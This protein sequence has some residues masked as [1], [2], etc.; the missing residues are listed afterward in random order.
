MKKLLVTLALASTIA[1]SVYGQGRILFNNTLGGGLVTVAADP[2]NQGPTGGAGGS[3]V[4][5]A[6]SIQLFY[7]AGTADQATFNATAIAGPITQLAAFGAGSEGIYDFGPQSP[8]AVGA[9]GTY[10][11]QARAWFNN[12]QFATYT[13]ALNAARNTGISELKTILATAAPTPANSTAFA[14]FTVGVIPEPSTFALAG[15]GAAALLLF[16]RRK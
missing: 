2:N 15:L 8:V 7:V 1:A 10:T 11:I 5:S 4:G 16:R 3:A 9:A 12:G 6:Y 13:D 14:A